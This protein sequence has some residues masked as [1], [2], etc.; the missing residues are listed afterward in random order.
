MDKWGCKIKLFANQNESD[1][2]G[3]S[4]EVADE[5]KDFIA[6]GVAVRFDSMPECQGHY[7]QSR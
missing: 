4:D 2:H 5:F 1:A 3:P 7:G 6:E